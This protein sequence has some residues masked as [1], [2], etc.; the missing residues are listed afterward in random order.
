ML[1]VVG[2]GVIALLVFAVPC[3]AFGYACAAIVSHY[4]RNR[5]RRA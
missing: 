4:N 2:A 3:I 5:N 1:I